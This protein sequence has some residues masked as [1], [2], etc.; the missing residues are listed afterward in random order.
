MR[1]FTLTELCKSSTAA[2]YG[3]KNTPTAAERDSLVALVDNILDPL[4]EA[5]GKP[6]IVNSGFRCKALN[7]HPA[8]GGAENSQHTKGEA[9]D[10]EAVSR[11]PED[12]RKLFELI[13]SMNLP[14]DQLINEFGYD[15]VH[16]SFSRG[17][18]RGSV[19]EAKRVGGKTTY[20]TMK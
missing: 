16:V 10:I 1:Y 14:F 7:S 5:W 2:R 17:K 3:I 4:R 9:V 13:R 19:L 15:W 8:V 20:L 6:I 18:R 11:D 12:N